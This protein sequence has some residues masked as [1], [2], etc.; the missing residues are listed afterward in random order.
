MATTEHDIVI[1]NVYEAIT[2][3]GWFEF[4]IE[5]GPKDILKYLVTD[6]GLSSSDAR[7]I[8]NMYQLESYANSMN[9]TKWS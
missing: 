2:N 8:L 6:Y 7:K 3:D 9:D 1:D 4:L 5:E